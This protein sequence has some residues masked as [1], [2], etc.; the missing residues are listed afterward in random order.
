MSVRDIDGSGGGARAD[1]AAVAVEAG[2]SD[3]NAYE[4]ADEDADVPEWAA[5]LD[6][7]AL[8]THAG[9]ALA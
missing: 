6:A 2:R 9:R 5:A 1:E 3:E 4:D 7:I 8:N